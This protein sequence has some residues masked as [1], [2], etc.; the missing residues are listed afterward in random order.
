MLIQKS[1]RVS[2]R[3]L[4]RGPSTSDPCFVVSHSS[5]ICL[6]L[7]CWDKAIL[8]G[9]PPG[10]TL[11][12]RVGHLCRYYTVWGSRLRPIRANEIRS[13]KVPLILSVTSS[14]NLAYG[15]LHRRPDSRNSP[16]SLHPVSD[17][18]KAIRYLSSLCRDKFGVSF[19]SLGGE[20]YC[21]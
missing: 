10:K 13:L 21:P 4:V 20:E 18:S 17:S 12:T 8:P 15:S 5:E 19:A 1:G 14:F 9:G 11:P 2:C 16:P 3:A 7:T 6:F